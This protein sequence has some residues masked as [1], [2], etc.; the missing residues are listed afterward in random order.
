MVPRALRAVPGALRAFQKVSS[1][2][3]QV[4]GGFRKFQVSGFKR[5]Q[6]SGG[7]RALAR[8]S[9]GFLRG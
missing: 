3:G 9:D 7:F 6:V 5:F 8:V 4:L 2:R 1:F